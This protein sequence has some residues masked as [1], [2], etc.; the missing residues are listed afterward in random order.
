MTAENA[1]ILCKY[2]ESAGT[3]SGCGEFVNNIKMHSYKGMGISGKQGRHLQDIYCRST[4]HY[5]KLFSRVEKCLTN[6]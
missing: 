5:K 1:L 4:G 6:R 2:I 3:P